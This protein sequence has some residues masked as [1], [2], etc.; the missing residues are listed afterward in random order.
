MNKLI[1]IFVCVVLCGTLTAPGAFAGECYISG[2]IAAE[3]ND[4]PDGVAW[5]YTLTVEWDTGS[6]YSLS[7][8]SVLLDEEGG[9]C[10]CQDF[11]EALSWEPVVG[12]STSGSSCETPY[13]AEL[14]CKGDPSIPGVSG[15]TFK[16]E[17]L[18]GCDPGTF[19][20][21][22]YKFYSDLPP[23]PI[24]EDVLSLVDKF[25]QNSCFGYLSGW[26]PGLPCDPVEVE[27]SSWGSVKGLY[28]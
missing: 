10:S 26:F 8:I 5:V 23:A 19:G 3:R 11:Y 28:R 24:N 6:R 4:D 18:E 12:K 2:T 16:L 15:I 17:P 20:S 21:G 1:L 9:T 14:G 22:V 13:A 27:D 7:H 25:G